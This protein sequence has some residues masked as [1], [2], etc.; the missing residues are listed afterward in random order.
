MHAFSQTG[1]RTCLPPAPT[2]SWLPSRP[3]LPPPMSYMQAPPDPAFFSTPLEL[4][5]DKLTMPIG[6]MTVPNM[7]LGIPEELGGT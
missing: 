3:R 6:N 1:V 7:R 5:Q 2:P 4:P